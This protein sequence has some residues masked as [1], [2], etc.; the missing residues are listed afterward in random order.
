MGVHCTGSL[1]EAAVR[2][3]KT[4]CGVE[5]VV[6][7]PAVLATVV[8]AVTVVVDNVFIHVFCV[9]IDGGKLPPLSLFQCLSLRVYLAAKFA[10][11][12]LRFA[13]SRSSFDL[14]LS[15]ALLRRC[16]LLIQL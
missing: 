13:L 9:V 14:R 1:A 2:V 3:V 8:L 4:N 11:V 6:Y 12:P 10:S 7:V 15:L 5:C 16:F